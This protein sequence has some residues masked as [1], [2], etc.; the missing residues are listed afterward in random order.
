MILAA[1]TVLLVA[2]LLYRESQLTKSRASGKSESAPA[3]ASSDQADHGAKEGA[4]SS[5]PIAENPTEASPT[6]ARF[7]TMPD[8]SPVPALSSDAPDKVKLG[9]VLVR[10]QGSQGASDSTRS[11]ESALMLANEINDLAKKDFNEAIKKGDRGSSENIGW[12][13]QRILER[14]VEHAVFSLEK[15]QVSESPIDTPR[16]FWIVKRL[17]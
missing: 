4:P 11:R 15:G 16:G 8:G 1:A 10:Y 6:A 7:H 9:I 13:K 3:A 12:I 5:E 2:G 14:S 17:R